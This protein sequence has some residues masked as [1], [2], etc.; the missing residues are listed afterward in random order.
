MPCWAIGELVGLDHCGIGVQPIRVVAR[1]RCWRGVKG[2]QRDKDGNHRKDQRNDECSA[3][4]GHLRRA[5]RLLHHIVDRATRAREHLAQD[6]PARFASDRRRA[7][8]VIQVGV[9]PRCVVMAATVTVND[10]LDRRVV[11]NLQC[12][13]RIYLDGYVPNLQIGGQVVTLMTRHLG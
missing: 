6:Q 1:A 8:L 2:R 10:L 11:P 9:R 3:H 12:L 5:Q 4:V 13:G 7:F